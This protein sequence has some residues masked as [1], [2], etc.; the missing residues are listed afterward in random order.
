MEKCCWNC[1]V[2][3]QDNKE[4]KLSYCLF[5]KRLQKTVSLPNLQYVLFY[6][7]NKHML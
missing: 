3:L 2:T 6:A 1:Q 4:H 5:E 7:I